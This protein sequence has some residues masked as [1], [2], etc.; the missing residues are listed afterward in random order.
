MQHLVHSLRGT[1]QF[2]GCN[3]LHSTLY[4]GYLF[5]KNEVITFN[6]L[7]KLDLWLIWKLKYKDMVVQIALY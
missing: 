7:S 5:S 1:E 6:F 2:A 3:I 4:I